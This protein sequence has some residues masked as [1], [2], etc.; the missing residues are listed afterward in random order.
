MIAFS[1]SLGRN[2]CAGGCRAGRGDHGNAPSSSAGDAPRAGEKAT[3]RAGFQ[4]PLA[5]PAGAGD[6]SGITSRPAHGQ[7]TLDTRHGPSYSDSRHWNRCA[8]CLRLSSRPI[9]SPRSVQRIA[10]GTRPAP[11]IPQSRVPAKSRR[12]LKGSRLWTNRDFFATVLCSCG[13]F[14]PKETG[15]FVSPMLG[16]S[17]RRLGQK[18]E[19]VLLCPKFGVRAGPG[20]NAR[21]AHIV[22]G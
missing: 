16:Q 18:G 12:D 11:I 21:Q 9:A 4:S 10:C 22:A 19:G 7:R 5:A 1:Q 3:L 17:A 13:V 15:F 6:A 14:R 8:P 2:R 20:A